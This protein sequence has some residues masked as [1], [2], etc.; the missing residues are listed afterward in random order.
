MNR[1]TYEGSARPGLSEG[2]QGRYALSG[3][4]T[5]DDLLR[6]LRGRTSPLDLPEI[7]GLLRGLELDADAL[8]PFTRFDPRRYARNPVQRHGLHELLLLCWLPGQASPF[9]DHAGSA[10]GVRVIRGALTETQA[11]LAE[12]G[13]LRARSHR[14]SPAGSVVGSN[15]VDVHRMENRGAEPLVTLHLYS[16]PLGRMREWDEAAPAGP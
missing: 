10:C 3:P 12:D 7:L 8:A 6:D 1:S 2:W 5:L 4:M 15:A 13:A 16:P 11:A 14:E 9:H